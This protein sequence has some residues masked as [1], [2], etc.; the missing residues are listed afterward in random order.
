MA[1]TKRFLFGRGKP[2]AT[3][4]A[5]SLFIVGSSAL[6][7]DASPAR[8]HIS[9][10]AY[11]IP[12]GSV[13]DAL[14][15]LADESGAQLLYDA[16]LTRHLMTSGVSGK[17][18]LDGAL[19]ELLG[20]TGLTYKI[21]PGSRSVSILLAQADIGRR[22]DAS[23]ARALPPI[24]VGAAT[25]P[26]AARGTARPQTTPV[27]MP[28][29]ASGDPCR[30]AGSTCLSGNDLARRQATAADTTDLLKEIPGV[31]HYTGG[32]VSNLPVIHGLAD[33]RLNILID[34]VNVTSACANHMN[35]PLSYIDPSRVGK[36]EVISGVTPVSK[37]GDSIGGSIIVEPAPPVFAQRPG[38][39][40]AS[41]RV[42]AFY[43]SNSD[44]P[45][46]NV[47]VRGGTDNVAFDYSF[48]YSKARSYRRGTGG[49]P[50][51]ATLW[52]YDR[53]RNYLRFLGNGAV[54]DGS[55]YEATH[56]SGRLAFKA[57]NGLLSF[58]I[59]GHHI[60]YQGFPNQP[61]DMTLN[62]SIQGGARYQGA[63]DWG[64]LDARVYY[65][66]TN[67]E[68]D[69]LLERTRDR[70]NH[71]LMKNVGVDFGYRLKAE[72]PIADQHL[73]RIGNEYH[74]FRLEDWYPGLTPW[75]QLPHD[76]ISV[77]AGRR[78]R[79]GTYAELQTKWSK[80]WSSLLGVRND[81]V[82]MNAGGGVHGYFDSKYDRAFSYPFNLANKARTDINFDAIASVRYAPTSSESFEIGF[83]RKTRSPNLYERYAWW[84]HNSMITWF[85]DGN[86]YAGNLN[87]K[88]EVAYQ[89]GINAEWR[90]PH[91]DDWFVRVSPYFTHVD[92]FIWARHENTT[93]PGFYGLQFVNADYA[94]LYG[95]DLSGRYAFLKGTPV[96]DF[97]LRGNL[98]FVRGTFH[99]DGRGRPCLVADLNG[100]Y[101]CKAYKWPLLGM[102][103]PTGGSLYHI[104]PLNGRI[105]LE[106]ALGNFTSALELQ[107]VDMK[108]YVSVVHGEPKTPG[109]ALLNLRAGYSF[110][111]FRIDAGIDNIFDKLYYP[112]LGGIAVDES[113]RPFVYPNPVIKR[114]IPGMGRSAWV[115]ASVEF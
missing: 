49:S 108:S 110:E 81:V 89:F 104:M 38:E 79:V 55:L 40:V 73:L 99:D 113:F 111:N 35:P 93:A 44:S 115:G 88:P 106:H 107:L 67:H 97:A 45:G 42:G 114:L 16:A 52:E 51:D 18:T 12:A 69:N 29:A 72:I 68:M 101:L 83:S 78:E 19:R 84:D 65:Q 37:G 9:A 86:G 22:S 21:D 27:A 43:R 103:G 48:A 8:A 75:Y 80:E 23:G 39:Y 74:Q 92:Q 47:T 41:G 15:T 85:G 13:A 76:F 70:K 62:N 58:D 77:H 87:L 59:A 71:M 3:A 17:R 63:F 32:G 60:P 82:W 36:V 6:A 56:H 14:N 1:E 53:A 112:P 5:I 26:R 91:G 34:G 109:Y 30:N 66:R 33:D 50:W 4:T 54:L 64:N 98:S 94:Q 105:A 25:R 95:V 31:S 11:D 102:Q 57:D 7:I 20:G 10:Q 96:G 24:E 28:A 46:V 90:D 2:A 100:G 61:M